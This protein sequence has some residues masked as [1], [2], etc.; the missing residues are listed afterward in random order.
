MSRRAA[1]GWPAALLYLFF[2]WNRNHGPRGS[3]GLL[4][5]NE[6]SMGLGREEF[7]RS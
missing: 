4:D 5:T 1:D 7:G 6:G 3:Q 2:L